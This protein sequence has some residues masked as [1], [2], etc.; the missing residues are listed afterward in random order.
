[1]HKNSSLDPE[2]K[3]KHETISIS[4]LPH[5]ERNNFNISRG[6]GD[7]KHSKALDVML[8][9]AI[10]KVTGMFADCIIT[11]S[12]YTI[13]DCQSSTLFGNKT[14]FSLFLH[15][16]LCHNISSKE[17]QYGRVLRYFLYC[18][19]KKYTFL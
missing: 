5:L 3:G 8:L 15:L 2:G 4:Q 19:H 9:S 11:S 10:L 1:V 6:G 16:L 18:F 7:R 13:A 14:R 17:H 12:A